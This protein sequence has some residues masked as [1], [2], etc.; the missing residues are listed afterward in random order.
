M[1]KPLPILT[2]IIVALTLVT[3]RAQPRPPTGPNFDGAM[4]KLFGFNSGFSATME[5]H[6]TDPTG[7]QMT[8]SAKM[9]HADGKSRIE[10]DMWGTQG[11]NMPP[12]VAARMKQMGMSKTTVINRSEKNVSYVIYPDM[13]AYT[14]MPAQSK[15]APASDYKVEV[16]KLGE[17]SID[18]H[19]CVKNK[20]V[21]TDPD[22][23]THEYT[24]WNASDLKQFPLKIET[25]SE[26]GQAMVM[27]FKDV[28][29]EKPDDAQF[30]PPSDFKKYDSMMS[31]MMSRARGGAPQ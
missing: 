10:M 26:N 29:L 18:G 31:L 12:Q 4:D 20:C 23:A 9:A 7:K 5:M 21:V 13:Q 24:V 3:A 28:K 25:K 16:T 15:Y 22:G 17:E 30:E 1:K 6:S 14:E 8:M 27:L 2:A 11:A 19:A